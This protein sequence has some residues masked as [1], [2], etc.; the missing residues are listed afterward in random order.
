MVMPRA[1]TT[2]APSGTVSSSRLPTA[3]MRLPSTS[4][5][6]PG[7]GGPSCPSISRPPTTARSAS[8]GWG[9]ASPSN[10]CAAGRATAAA[11][12]A[13]PT[14]KR[15][16]VEIMGRSLSAFS[17]PPPYHRAA[18]ATGAVATPGWRRSRARAPFTPSTAVR[19]EGSRSI[20]RQRARDGIP[21]HQLEVLIL[22]R[23]ARFA[24]ETVLN[25]EQTGRVLRAQGHGD[26]VDA[27]RVGD[28]SAV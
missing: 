5:T 2:S 3:T 20:Q 8:A 24:D 9:S 19:N 13:A 22:L 7:S 6:A 11:V 26:Q 12:S 15:R 28:R 16:R 14:R 17:V 25:H 18:H 4:T 23:S 21:R 1:S 10:V 27:V